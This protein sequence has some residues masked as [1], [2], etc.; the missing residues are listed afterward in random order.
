MEVSEKTVVSP[1]LQTEARKQLEDYRSVVHQ[2]MQLTGVRFAIDD[3]GVGN[4]SLSRLDRLKPHYVKVDR[5]IL[6]FDTQMAS[7]LIRYLIDSQNKQGAS[8]ILEG[9]DIHSKLSLD[10]LV[11]DI[12]VGIIQGHSLSKAV[13]GFDAAWEHETCERVKRDLGWQSTSLVIFRQFCNRC[14]SN[15]GRDEK[16]RHR[17]SETGIG[18]WLFDEWSQERLC[19]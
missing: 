9:V 6:S 18:V 13:T 10:E 2:L 16:H 5:D 15:T 12:G 8:V 4:S 1:E 3:F 19:R 14:L 7:T 17:Y 11:K